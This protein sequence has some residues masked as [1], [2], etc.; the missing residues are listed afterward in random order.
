MQKTLIY[1]CK[2]F[3]LKAEFFLSL[4]SPVSV[5]RWCCVRFSLQ[6]RRF[7]FRFHLKC[8]F[9]YGCPLSTP[10][11]HFSAVDICLC[12]ASCTT[13]ISRNVTSKMRSLSSSY[14]K[15]QIRSVYFVVHAIFRGWNENEHNRCQNCLLNRLFGCMAKM[16]IKR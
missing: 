13:S 4:A 7:S 5:W 6:C 11:H 16:W 1:K 12:C 10:F 3:S 9:I 15:L 8:R 2:T 14:L